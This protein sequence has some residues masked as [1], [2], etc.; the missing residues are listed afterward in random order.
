MWA[1]PKGEVEAASRRFVHPSGADVGKESGRMPL[2]LC[3]AHSVLAS[4][5]PWDG[6]QVKRP[7]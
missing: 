7:R 6:V 3:V 4:A 1:K 2:P 5:G